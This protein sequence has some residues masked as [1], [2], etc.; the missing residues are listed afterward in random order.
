MFLVILRAS[1]LCTLYI[2][3]KDIPNYW[4]IF[5]KSTISSANI[6]SKPLRYTF[7]QNMPGRVN[8][9]DINVRVIPITNE[10]TLKT[11]AIDS[12]AG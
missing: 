2:L 5:Y 10:M 9:I 3:R 6:S 11:L 1:D 12:A 4:C 8:Q 7:S